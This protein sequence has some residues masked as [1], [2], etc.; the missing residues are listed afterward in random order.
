MLVKQYKTGYIII[1]SSINSPDLPEV[2]NI[3]LQGKNLGQK[4]HDLGELLEQIANKVEKIRIL[5][6]KDGSSLTQAAIHFCL[7][8]FPTK[9]E[10]KTVRELWKN[11][12]INWR[13]EEIYHIAYHLIYQN[14]FSSVD[15]LLNNYVEN[16]DVFHLTTFGQNLLN[17]NGRYSNVSNEFFYFH[18]LT[19]VLNE[20]E[21]NSK[22][23]EFVRKMSEL[24]KNKQQV[25]IYFLQ[26]YCKQ[27]YK[28]GELVDFI[29]LYYRL[30][31]E[32]L[33]YAMGWDV[34]NTNQYWV[35]HNAKRKVPFEK[36]YSRHFTSYLNVVI[37]MKE[38]DPANKFLHRLYGDFTQEWLIHFL[39]LRHE[40]ISGHGFAQYS[41]ELFEEI[42]G[43]NP[44]EKMDE[45]LEKYGM[46][47]EYDIF[48]L[49]QKALL[50]LVRQAL[51][52][53][54]VK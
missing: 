24:V 28:T 9:T 37:K 26:N 25:F 23:V 17:G 45:L 16:K 43:G 52:E 51:I 44:V 8:H 38:K 22:E 7:T 36:P 33:L 27:L 11:A 49:V 53:K 40:G 19:K 50:A 2:E 35:R 1:H 42:C 10:I 47:A 39:D 54:N 30:A 31:E 12:D 14:K 34:D 48:E 29:V 41:T 13:K 20:I 3:R 21:A 5:V 4:L 18:L 6:D 15:L 32:L 46:K